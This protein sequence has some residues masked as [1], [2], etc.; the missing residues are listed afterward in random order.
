MRHYVH[1]CHINRTNTDKHR[2]E[3]Q[4]LGNE[5]SHMDRPN[6]EGYFPKYKRQSLL[7][8]GAD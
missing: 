1:I 5:R 4:L 7:G 6:R 8:L 3:R 2:N